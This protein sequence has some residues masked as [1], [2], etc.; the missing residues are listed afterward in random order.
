M[1]HGSIAS[2]GTVTNAVYRVFTSPGRLGEWQD[3]LTVLR[4]LRED[5][6]INVTAISTYVSSIRIQL[7]DLYPERGEKLQGPRDGE[8]PTDRGPGNFYRV[9]RI[10]PHIPGQLTLL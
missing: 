1:H 8:Q 9:V 2:E 10:P 5:Y 3:P 6:Q 4:V 7:R